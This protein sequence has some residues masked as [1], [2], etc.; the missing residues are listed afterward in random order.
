[1]SITNYRLYAD[2]KVNLGWQ[3][4]GKGVLATSGVR[5][6]HASLGI[7]P[8]LLQLVPDGS[9][10]TKFPHNQGIRNLYEEPAAILDCLASVQTVSLLMESSMR[11]TP[12][13][14]QASGAVVIT[15][16]GAGYVNALVL[17]GIRPLILA[18]N[19][20]STAA[21]AWKVYINVIDGG[22]GTGHTVNV[23]KDSARTQLV[24]TGTGDDLGAVTLAESGNSGVSGTMT[25]GTVV[26]NDIDIVAAIGTITYQFAALPT[27]Y[28]SLFWDDGQAVKVLQDCVVKKL[29]VT[30]VGKDAVYISTELLAMS[31]DRAGAM[32]ATEAAMNY[33]YYITADMAL[34]LEKIAGGTYTIEPKSYA[35]D[36]DG[37]NLRASDVNSSVPTAF[38]EGM[39]P[40]VN[41][42][43]TLDY[44]DE[45]K[46]IEDQHAA[47]LAAHDLTVAL[48]YED[49]TLTMA[50]KNIHW[51]EAPPIEM[52]HGDPTRD[53]VGE[54]GDF[55]AKGQAK[56]SLGVE[57]PV[58]V[59]LAYSP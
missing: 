53:S 26:G 37:E 21:S 52:T 56:E 18:G 22:G 38:L 41:S 17:N 54:L 59:T 6:E 11:G 12:T 2:C 19:I 3:Y 55:G 35:V 14:T 23:Y 58:A 27:R 30:A 24:A 45:A 29:R 28:F 49:L 1:M 9:H 40:V 34:T 48:V 7:N 44:S 13:A 4:G 20:D 51:K 42:E 33:D 10:G 31:I 36:F 5:I 39:A 32:P 57:E 47:A 25:L 46:E 50:M 15:A 16:D 8:N 43:I